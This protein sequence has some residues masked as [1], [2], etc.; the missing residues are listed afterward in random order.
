[1]HTDQS[2]ADQS[3]PKQLER[4]LW[5]QPFDGELYDI[6]PDCSFG[7]GLPLTGAPA[8]PDTLPWVHLPAPDPHA[9]TQA[10]AAATQIIGTGVLAEEGSPEGVLG[11][12]PLEDSLAEKE[13]VA[14]RGLG[15]QEQA[16]SSN[17]RPAVALPGG[18]GALAGGFVSA[19]NSMAVMQQQVLHPPSLPLSTLHTTSISPESWARLVE[20]GQDES[21]A[22]IGLH[23]PFV[24]LGK[25]TPT[26]MM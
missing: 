25:W 7:V 23:K 1:M 5:T 9:V 14:L 3:N 19:S 22:G 16:G 4:P 8:D 21:G 13:E 10:Q 24:L 20:H 26:S 12:E 6:E 11:S 17:R 15:L 18:L 2:S